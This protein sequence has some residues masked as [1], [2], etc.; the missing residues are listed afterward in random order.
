MTRSQ[1]IENIKGGY[2]YRFDELPQEHLDKNLIRAWL[3]GTDGVLSQVPKHL[4]DDDIRRHAI[5]V[6]NEDMDVD[7]Y[8]LKYISME[9]T[10]CYEE[11]AL[12]AIDQT[13]WNMEFVDHALYSEAFFLKALEINPQALMHF[14]SDWTEKKIEIEW[15]EAMIASAVSKSLDYL[16]HFDKSQVKKESLECLIRENDYRP[17]L[18]AGAGLI[19]VM[20]GM[21][22]EGYWPAMVEKPT[23]LED[24]LRLL[25][26]SQGSDDL[27][28]YYKAFVR[29]HPTKDVIQLMKSPKLQGLMLEVYSAEELMPHLR[30]GLLKGHAKVR[31]KLL[32]QGL[33]L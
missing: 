17:T 3:S 12:L 2:A 16:E 25:L 15:T 5:T 14:F 7:D 28:V 21:M 4:V 1:L 22:R 33:G 9:D 8:P 27:M 24:G 30:A 32:E 23:S 26:D 29:H 20:S 18:I 10:Q 31:G 11:L 13:E 6:T 19:D